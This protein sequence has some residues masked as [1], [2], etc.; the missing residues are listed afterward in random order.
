MVIKFE[1]NQQNLIIAIL[2]GQQY[3]VPSYCELYM[4]TYYT[5]HSRK[6]LIFLNQKNYT[7]YLYILH[8]TGRPKILYTVHV[9]TVKGTVLNYGPYNLNTKISNKFKL[10]LL[11]LFCKVTVYYTKIHNLQRIQNTCSIKNIQYTTILNPH[12]VQGIGN[13]STV[14]QSCAINVV[15]CKCLG[16]VEIIIAIFKKIG[17]LPTCRIRGLA[18][19]FVSP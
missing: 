18:F 6:I 10:Y 8:S 2:K 3:L 12:K 11:D 13:Y 9:I 5:Y 17:V 1:Y 19:L 4:R 14:Y 16:S 15:C 7:V